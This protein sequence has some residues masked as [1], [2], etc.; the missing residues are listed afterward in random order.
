M[1]KV[2]AKNYLKEGSKDD[3]LKLVEELIEETR[4]EAG[5]ISYELFQSKR[6]PNE[7]TFIETWESSDALKAHTQAE[8]FTRIIPQLRVYLTTDMVAD[9][10]TLIK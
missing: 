5:C 2:V 4:L 7:V 10:Y 8:H 9:V 3:V 6:D 1:I